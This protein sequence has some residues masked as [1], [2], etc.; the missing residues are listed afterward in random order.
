MM[1]ALWFLFVSFMGTTCPGKVNPDESNLDHVNL[2]QG[3]SSPSCPHRL[4][5]HV[6]G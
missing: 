4:V 5:G 3:S 2:E 1:P 6:L